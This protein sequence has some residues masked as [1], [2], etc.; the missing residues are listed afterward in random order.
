MSIDAGGR[1]TLTG[2]RLLCACAIA[3]VAGGFVLVATRDA[4]TT[5]PDSSVYVGTAR[6]LDAGHGLNVPIHYYPLGSVSIGTPPLGRFTPQPTPLVVYAPLEPVL[7]A[8]GGDPLNAARIEDAVFFALAV[9]VVGLFILVTTGQPWL[10]AAAQLVV[11]GSLLARVADVGTTAASLFLIVVALAATIAFRQQPLRRWLII[12]SLAT[13]LATLERYANGGLIVWGVLALRSRRR[14]ALA[15][16]VM[17]SVPLAAW[18]I[19]ERIAGRG[20]GHL[21]GFHVVGGSF[22]GG[23]RSVAD[24]ILPS[25]IPSAIALLAAI[26]VVVAVLLVVRRRRTTSAQLLVLYAVVQIVILEVAITFFDAEVNLDSRELVPC[27]VAVVMALACSIERTPAVRL[28]VAAAVVGSLARGGVE[29]ASDLPAGYAMP[30]WVHS[31][32]MAAVRKLPARTIIYTNAPD[33]SY[34][35][36]DRAPASVPETEDFSTLKRNPRLGAQLTEIGHTLS[37]RGGVVV[38][39]RG[40]GRDYLPSEASLVQVL[41]LRLIRQ[42][43]DG[44]IYALSQPAA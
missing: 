35:L 37:T 17:S 7:L 40:L 20:S 26:A 22:R 4:V 41:R 34:L 16:L 6:S 12:A 44:A 29:M 23:A 18:F 31:P 14:D 42:T 13:G 5:G 27:F 25:S 9:L 8:A 1:V 21:A 28:L 30:R 32:I 38:Y 24:W 11:G 36:A 15:F 19:Y 33:A 2:K 39:V 10:S 43:S 3:L